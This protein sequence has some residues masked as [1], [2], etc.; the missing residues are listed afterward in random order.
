MFEEADPSCC[1]F[2]HS[3]LWTGLN[4]ISYLTAKW[5]TD[6]QKTQA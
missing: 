4:K 5:H 3:C 1:K 6:T 2:R